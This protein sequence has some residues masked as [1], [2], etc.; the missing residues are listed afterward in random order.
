MT[1]KIPATMA[2]QHPDNAAA[3]F[4]DENQPFISAYKEIAEA[5][6][7]FQELGVSECMWDWEGKHA[8]AAIID[9]LFTEYHD[10][11]AEHQLGRDKFLTFR[12]PNIWEEKGYNLMQ[13][14]TVILSSE[15]FARDIGFEK[16]PLFEVILPMTERADQVLHMQELFQKLAQFK[17]TDFTAKDQANDD[18]LELIPLVE[19][20]ESQHAAAQL[21][22]EYVAL[23][24]Q[25]FG[26]KPESLRMFLACSDPALAAGHL[27]TVIANKIALS[28]LTQF[29]QTTGIAVYPIMGA[30]SLPFRGGLAPNTVDRFV[31]EYPGVRT[32]SVQSAFRYDYPQYEV[33][34]AIKKLEKIL[35]EATP[36]QYSA[37]ERERLISI[38]AISQKHYQET[39]D[40]IAGDMQPLFAAFPKRRDRRQHI[41]LLSYGRSVGEQK[42]PRAI[43][44]TGSFYAL[45]VPPELIGFG[46]TMR[47]LSQDDVTF[48]KEKYTSLLNDLQKIGGFLNRDNV[49]KL[50]E[51]N[52]AWQAVAEDIAALEETFGI[53]FEAATDEQR[54][55]QRLSAE[56][57]AARED[58][59]RV[60][61]LIQ[62]TGLLRKALG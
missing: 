60:S 18:Y 49:R 17:S 61:E 44:F 24:E 7:N 9:R 19:S 45:G 29:S 57:F 3:P 32:V 53:Q 2:T 6:I 30:G 25:H 52:Q 36:L 27:A 46:R 14:M 50:A 11:F 47:E 5:V 40:G 42:L 31:T 43:T 12:I 35:P 41:G 34:D 8:D 16:R 13:A 38:S 15:D 4:W 58:K 33:V 26:R 56:V 28:D 10:Y 1:R 59:T 54:E 23:H 20:V 22:T 55:H 21:L 51:T 37:D 39:L 62:Q 48:L